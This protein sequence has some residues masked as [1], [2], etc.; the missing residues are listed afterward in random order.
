M[1]MLRHASF[2]YFLALFMAVWGLF[3]GGSMA[4]MNHM[5]SGDVLKT[6]QNI[7]NLLYTLLM[8]TDCNLVLYR[9]PSV[10]V[11]S[12]NTNGK[13]RECELRLKTDGN[14][15]IY[16]KDEKLIW[17]TGT[18]GTVGH[19]VLL[20]QRDLNLVVYSVPAWDS[21]TGTVVSAA[22]K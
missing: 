1:A 3:A 11:W 19:Y 12:T 2:F 5:L 14:L 20:L 10:A 4:Q 7:S 6:G 9:N 18:N 21:G 22:T 17:Q 15:V 8:Q 13:G 16:G